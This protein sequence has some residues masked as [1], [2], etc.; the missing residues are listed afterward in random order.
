MNTNSI[1]S[2]TTALL[3]ILST[4]AAR[5]TATAQKEIDACTLL[6]VGDASKALEQEKAKEVALAK[7]MVG[8]L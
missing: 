6:T 8:K 2:V 1:A 7:A 3:L 5:F 4:S